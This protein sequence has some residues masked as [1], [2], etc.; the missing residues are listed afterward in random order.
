[1]TSKQVIIVGCGIAGT[2][3]AFALKNVESIV[4]SMNLKKPPMIMLVFICI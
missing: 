4:L 2:S 3:L 1:M